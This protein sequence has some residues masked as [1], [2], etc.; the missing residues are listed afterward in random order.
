M[1]LETYNFKKLRE[2]LIKETKQKIASSIGPDFM[3][4]QAINAISDIDKIANTLSKRLQEWF[5]LFNPEEIHKVSYENFV[6][7]IL[8]STKKGEMGGDF[9]EADVKMIKVF[10]E[11]LSDLIK[12]KQILIDYIKEKMQICAPRVLEICG[13]LIG[14][15]LIAHKGNLRDLAFMPASTIQILGA[16]K[17]LFRHL[18]SKAKSPKYGYLLQHQEVARAQNK[19]KA[20]RQ[21]ANRISKAAKQDYFT[22]ERN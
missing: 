22:N 16:E 15:K 3:V 8:D 18:R 4:T 19:G 5:G 10:A 21:L 7:V 12:E 20:A 11:R 2:D 9:S 14:A 13:P 6:G 17:A 1:S